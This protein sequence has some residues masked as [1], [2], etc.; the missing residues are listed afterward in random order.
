MDELEALE[1][2]RSENLALTKDEREQKK[3]AFLS[4][5]RIYLIGAA[6]GLLLLS[7]FYFILHP[8]DRLKLCFALNDNYA[9]TTTVKDG[10]KKIGHIEVLVDGNIL[11]SGGKYYEINE[12]QSYVYR[13]NN[14]KWYRHPYYQNDDSV[15]VSWVEDLLDKD[16]YERSFFPWAPMKYTEHFDDDLENVRMQ[17]LLGRFIISGEILRSNG[18]YYKSFPTTI[19]IDNFGLV[20]LELPEE[21]IIAN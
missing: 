1:I 18:I 16:N 17:M 4:D 5:I 14:G 9:I 6:C 7:I 2:H 10:F 13:Q 19:E 8:I 11:Y 20:N 3:R 21:Y 15:D 12:D